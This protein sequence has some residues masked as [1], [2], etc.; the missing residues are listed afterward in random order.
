[1]F[2]MEKN[3]DS[4]NKGKISNNNNSNNDDFWRSSMEKKTNLN[5]LRNW[6]GKHAQK[7]FFLL[8]SQL[9]NGNVKNHYG[10]KKS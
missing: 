8:T 7:Y 3:N 5:R 10:K 9:L 4:S 6:S 2:L 1:M